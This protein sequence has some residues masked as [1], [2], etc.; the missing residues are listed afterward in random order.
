MTRFIFVFSIYLFS[1]STLM[2]QSQSAIRKEY[3]HGWEMYKTGHYDMAMEILKPLTL[4]DN[5]STYSPYAGYYYSLAAFN[6]GYHYLAE[7]MLKSMSQK[8]PDWDQIDFVHL[9]LVKIYFVERE[10]LN[11]LA[12]AIQVKKSTLKKETDELVKQELFA[13]DSLDRLVSFYEEFPDYMALGEAVADRIVMQPI[14]NQD[15]MLLTEIVQKFDLNRDKYNIIDEISSTKKDEYNVA[16]LFPF[17]LSDIVPNQVKRS[18]EFIL[19]MYEG[20]KIAHDNLR[21]KGIRLNLYAFDTKMDS[22]TTRK[23]IQSG[24]LDGVDLIIGPLYPDPVRIVSE[25]S[26][27]NRINMFNPL[28]T[29]SNLIAN[30][31]FCFLMKPSAERQSMEAG[32]YVTRNLENPNGLI[33]YERSER[34]SL[35]A[36]TFKQQIEKDSFDIVMMK[37]IRSPDSVNVY[38]FLTYKI[39]F[40]KLV[41][42]PE[43]SV[44]IID[45]YHLGK[46]IEEYQNQIER[47]NRP[48]SVEILMIAPD[49]I[50]YIFVA[51][52]SELIGANT[53]SGVETRG[54]DILIVGNENWLDFKSLSLEQL[55]MLNIVLIA[56]GYI[57]QNNHETEAINTKIIESVHK[58]PNK[59]HYTGYELL[60]FVGEMLHEY[61]VYFQ[62]GMYKIGKYPGVIFEG[63]DYTEGNDNAVVPLILFEKSEFK[64]VN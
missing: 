61:G 39:N 56:P 35:M 9:W 58:I 24:Q 59:Y 40:E 14:L 38:N 4:P 21:K 16:I 18:N 11:G 31:P 53:I 52:N 23:I 22:I 17:M 15:R 50:G 29:N 36:F 47:G 54:D 13:I 33:F 28:S 8:Y 7:E 46:A 19:D 32:K 64:I 57:A 12:N 60:H 2:G 5:E 37:E 20:M 6:K 30:N 49:S 55:E 42:S 62:T 45:K 51:S 63:F 48:R 3:L 25:F 44:R 10:Y 1:F 26:F 27:K 34:D 43:D 41:F